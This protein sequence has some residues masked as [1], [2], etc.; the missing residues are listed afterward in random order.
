MEF[1]QVLAV[2]GNYVR[3][4]R[5]ADTKSHANFCEALAA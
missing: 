4:R 2:F 1:L 3:D 5:P